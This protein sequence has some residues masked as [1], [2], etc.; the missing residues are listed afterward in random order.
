[1]EQLTG[2]KPN[3]DNHSPV[4][5]AANSFSNRLY[6]QAYKLDNLL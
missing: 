1:M 5:K 3:T 6:D 4:K 2:Q